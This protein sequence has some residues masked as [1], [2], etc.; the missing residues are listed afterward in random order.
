M[1]ENEKM[2]YPKCDDDCRALIEKFLTVCIPVTTTPCVKVGKIK[3]ECCGNPII[4]SKKHEKCCDD[5][6]DGSCKFTIIQKM[7]IEIPIDFNAETK[8]D[9]FF[10]DCELKHDRDERDEKYDRE[11]KY[12]KYEKYDKCE[13]DEKHD[14]DDKCDKCDKEEK[15]DHECDHD[16]KKEN[17]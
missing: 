13:K 16:K 7:K 14:K 9:D 8:I 3:T 5:M 11:E 17:Y 6:K 2:D 10:V 1:F 4:A 12:E 15:H